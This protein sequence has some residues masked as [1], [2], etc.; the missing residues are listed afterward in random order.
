MHDAVL[1]EVK[2]HIVLVSTENKDMLI[3]GFSTMHT[4]VNN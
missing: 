3:T 1:C 4:E 2:L